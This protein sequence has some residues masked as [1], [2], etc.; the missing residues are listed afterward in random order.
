M[1]ENGCIFVSA[2]YSQIELRI[3]AHMSK[4]PV[5]L[6]SFLRGED[7]HSR[8]AEELFGVPPDGVTP[9]LRRKAKAINFGIVYGMG[10]MGFQRNSA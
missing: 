10:R 5:L 8:T 3:L 1:P 4:D 9:E 6:S 2:D 7:I